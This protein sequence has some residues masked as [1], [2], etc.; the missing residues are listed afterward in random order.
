MS[1]DVYKTS[2]QL[3]AAYLMERG[4]YCVSAIPAKDTRFPERKDFIFTDVVEPK[5]LEDDFY[6]YKR[7]TLSARSLLEKTRTT[8][9]I[10]RNGFS[11][12]DL[13]KL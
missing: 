3:F 1:N 7:E 10:L 8:R 11:D 13:K 9:H 4:F 6:R 12:E 2:D 5:S